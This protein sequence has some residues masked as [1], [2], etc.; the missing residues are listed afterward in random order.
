MAFAVRVSRFF[1]SRVCSRTDRSFLAVAQGLKKANDRFV[2]LLLSDVCD[3]PRSCDNLGS[4]QDLELRT[5]PPTSCDADHRLP[6]VSRHN[7]I[8]FLH[9]QTTK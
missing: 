7:L 1:S 8:A 5:V 4:S 2:A 9:E 6:L 3:S